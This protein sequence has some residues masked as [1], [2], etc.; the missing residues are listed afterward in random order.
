MFFKFLSGKNYQSSSPGPSVA[1]VQRGDLDTLASSGPAI[2]APV[3]EVADAAMIPVDSLPA[4]GLNNM[5]FQG[6]GKPIFKIVRESFQFRFSSFVRTKLG[7]SRSL[8][9]GS[10]HW[11]A[12]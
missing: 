5:H 6:P 4:H 2:V 3:V 8:K 9:V 7:L 11:R 1:L 12:Q 10:R